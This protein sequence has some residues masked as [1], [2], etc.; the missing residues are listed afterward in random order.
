MFNSLRSW[1]CRSDAPN[2][3]SERKRVIEVLI[4]LSDSDNGTGEGT[5][6]AGYCQCEGAGKGSRIVADGTKLREKEVCGHVHGVVSRYT[7]LHVV[8]TRNW[9]SCKQP[10]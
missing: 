5:K 10:T 7:Y 8:I 2:E 4:V 1:P 9:F 6:P 3:S